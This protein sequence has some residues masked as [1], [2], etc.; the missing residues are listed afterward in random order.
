MSRTMGPQVIRKRERSNYS[1]LAEFVGSGR[2][3]DHEDS[4]MLR[5]DTATQSSPK[6]AGSVSRLS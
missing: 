6:A 2:Q 4:A 1:Q 3:L 5:L